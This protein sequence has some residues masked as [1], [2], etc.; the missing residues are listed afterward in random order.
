MRWRNW[1]RTFSADPVSVEA[2]ASVEELSTLIA[3]VRG[4]G[5]GVKPIGASHSFSA[6]AQP[7][8]VQVR[9]DSF[10]GLLAVDL[11]RS[12]A[13]F[14]A[15]TRLYQASEL[16]APFGLAMANLGDIDR[17]SIAGAISTGTH[18]TGVGLPSIGATVTGA[19]IV[20]GTGAV[21]EV[22]EDQ[23]SEL[24]PAIRLGLGALG[25]IVEVELQCVPAFILEARERTEPLEDV[26]AG[27]HER[28]RTHDHFEFYW[29]PHADVVT[30]KTNMRIADKPKPLG[31]ATRLTDAWLL[32]GLVY[33]LI[34]EVESVAPR[35]IPTL[36]RLVAPLM[37]RP[38]FSDRSDRVF[39]TVRPIRF[40]EMEFAVPI[41]AVPDVVRELGRMIEARGHA[42]GFPIEARAAAADDAMLSTAYEREV[43]YIALHTYVR[44]DP[45]KIFADAQ[46]ILMAYEGR[47]HWGKMHS[48]THEHFA[49]RLP[50]F[51]DFLAVR[52]QLD[53][54]RVFANEYTRTV[55]GE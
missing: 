7:E 43:G 42:V 52:D 23:N 5:I 21:L 27:W 2:P 46:S 47:P 8:G 15:G 13:R 10:Q 11:Q 40:R 33:G 28:V 25:V 6:V 1:G 17:Q 44:Q 18:G 54:D 26:L 14:G 49:T 22:S 36:N 41:E 3:S 9:L 32:G 45:R 16:L 39:A 37:A 19:T 4:T 24:L 31:T 29:F 30:T 12:R 20:T 51:A 38:D 48:M 34:N 53:P 55:L 50:R 35:T